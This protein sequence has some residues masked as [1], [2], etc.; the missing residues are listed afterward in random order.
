MPSPSSRASLPFLI[1]LT[2]ACLLLVCWGR[3]VAE[4]VRGQ[5]VRIGAGLLGCP[6][7]ACGE[8]APAEGAETSGFFSLPSPAEPKPYELYVR[9]N[10]PGVDATRMFDCVGGPAQEAV[11]SLP[12]VR[13]SHADNGDGVSRLRFTIDPATPPDEAS[14][15]LVD[16]FATAG[17]GYLNPVVSREEDASPAASVKEPAVVR[18]AEAAPAPA[19]EPAVVEDPVAPET[20]APAEEPAVVEVPVV[21]ETPAPAEVSAPAEEV[22]EPRGSRWPLVVVVLADGSRLEGELRREALAVDSETLG[23]LSLP[24][25]SLSRAESGESGDPWLFETHSGDELRVRPVDETLPLST[26]FGEISI[27]LRAVKSI[28]FPKG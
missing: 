27:P 10:L 3:G 7:L 24:I 1:V 22:F 4:R 25:S 19:E 14:K 6:E 23:R 26:D 17:L 2:V 18:V 5:V 15:A 13:A 12:F 16:A 11:I 21:A 8:S 9:I 20:P 28:D